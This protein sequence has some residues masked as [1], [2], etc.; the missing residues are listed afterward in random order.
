[1]RRA[2]AQFF[3]NPLDAIADIPSGARISVGGF[4]CCG[5]PENLLRALRDFGNYRFTVSSMSFGTAGYGPNILLESKQIKRVIT[6]QLGDSPEAQN[7]YLRGELEIEL[8]PEGTLA[9]CIRAAGAGIPGF[10]TRTGV[11]TIIERGEYPIKYM[12]GGGKVEIYSPCK[13]TRVYGGVKFLFEESLESD[14]SLIKA[15]KADTLGN[16]VYRRT[17]TNFNPEMAMSSPCTIVEAEEIV[18]A[19]EIPPEAVHTPGIFV[20]RVIKGEN[21]EK[22]VEAVPGLAVS[23]GKVRVAQRTALELVAGMGVY[24][25][26]GIPSLVGNF[27]QEPNIMICT[28]SGIFGAGHSPEPHEEDPDIVNT[29]RELTTIKQGGAVM[30]SIEALDILRGGHL[31]ATVLGGFQVSQSG[32]LANWVVTGEYMRG[33]GSSMDCVAHTGSKLIVAMLHTHKGSPKVLKNCTFPLTGA[34]CVDLLITELCVFDFRRQNGITLTEIAKGT[35]L[36]EIKEKTGCSFN[37]ASDLKLMRA[38]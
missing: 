18:E 37:V 7:Q 30:S 17:A 6:S 29:S 11:N 19:G 25:G 15:W 33:I 21:Y 36:D 34:G 5:V 12:K 1:M 38:K 27:L 10:Y 8:V 9:A 2:I 20:Q 23:A 35:S 24:L 4:G 26:M 16:L 3:T 31:D 14:Y 22:P 13:E 28:S 32:D